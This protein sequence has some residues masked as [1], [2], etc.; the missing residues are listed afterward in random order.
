MLKM[1]LIGFFGLITLTIYSCCV[2]A[3][4][5]EDAMQK[6]I[7]EEERRKMGM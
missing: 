4:R 3:G 2:I 1:I 7:E 6:V 5:A